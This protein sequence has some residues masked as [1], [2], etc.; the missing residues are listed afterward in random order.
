[1]QERQ[2]LNQLKQRAD[3]LYRIGK[4]KDDALFEGY[5]Q[6]MRIDLT[7][8]N[9]RALTGF[10][11][12]LKRKYQI[13]AVYFHEGDVAGLIRFTKLFIRGIFII[14]HNHNREGGFKTVH[15]M[16]CNV[17]EKDWREA[18]A[19]SGVEWSGVLTVS[20]SKELEVVLGERLKKVNL[21]KD[22]NDPETEGVFTDRRNLPSRKKSKNWFANESD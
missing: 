10:L 18:C 15:Q 6:P 4:F 22:R 2:D 13:K 11:R 1:M 20:K 3:N 5:F 8:A 17:L 12:A 16:I 19:R 9:K 21:S 14:T 7:Q